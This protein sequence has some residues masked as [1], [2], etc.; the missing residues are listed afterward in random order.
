M[1]TLLGT[2]HHLINA[3][4]GLDPAMPPVQALIALNKI[5]SQ[6]SAQ[7]A[8]G[9]PPTV[10]SQDV[11]GIL[12]AINNAMPK[13]QPQVAPQVAPQAEPQVEEPE[14]MAHGGITHLPANFHF[15][16]GGIIAFKEGTDEK[17]VQDTE[18]EMSYGEQM[19]KLGHALMNIPLSIVGAPGHGHGILSPFMND[20]PAPQ[21][22]AP[23]AD[24]TQAVQPVAQAPQVQPPVAAPQQK[25]PVAPPKL[26][27]QPQVGIQ[28]LAPQQSASDKIL[29]EQMNAKSPVG[30]DYA[31]EQA[32][33]ADA[34]PELKQPAM[35][36]MEKHLAD[37]EAQDAQAK[38][39]RE[40]REAQRNLADF[41]HNL[42]MAGRASAGQTGIGSLL[43][44]YGN[45]SH[46][47]A[48]DAMNR[49]DAYE[50]ADRTHAIEM[51]KYHTEIE[52]ARRAEARGDF[53]SM[54]TAKEKAQEALQKVDQNKIA[55]AAHV[56][57]FES[58]ERIHQGTNEAN[59]RI[60][61][62]NRDAQMAIHTMPSSEQLFAN[63]YIQDY[64]DKNKGATYY[65][66]V[67]AYKQGAAGERNDITMLKM[68]ADPLTNNDKV[69]RDAAK[70]RLAQMA[71]LGGGGGGGT[72]PQ[73]AIDALKAN[74][75]L[76]AQFDAKFGAGA[77][78]KYLGQ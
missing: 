59:E 7:G 6:I 12:S 39:D 70:A 1:Q 73:G 43:G 8:G 47:S 17:G 2:V 48:M 18:P 77:S 19:S 69:T 22:Q 68:M 46:Q 67:N 65:E 37:L 16:H 42:S 45:V 49:Q 10:A 27:V 50:Q 14:A 15:D 9:N 53:A 35:S 29:A 41:F 20:N 63:K 21:A 32:K 25:L 26:S 13:K 55:A 51:A 24:P 76:K 4:N 23:V 31:A 54:L 61:K 34:H 57:G 30:I 75:N 40:R 78:A 64:L 3:V 44:N 60:A 66:A 74:P 72:I 36:G 38:K 62:A 11:S 52:N 5:K 71:G 56:A 28:T 58:Q 33:W